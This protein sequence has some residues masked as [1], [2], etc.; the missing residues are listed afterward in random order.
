MYNHPYRAGRRK[1]F[2][3]LFPALVFLAGGAVMLLWNAILPD[4][5]QA[6]HITYWQSVGL[7]VLCRILFGGFHFG[8]RSRFPFGGPPHLRDK[9]ANMTEEERKQFKEQ[10]RKRWD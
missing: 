7:L 8:P 4:L 2:L 6:N 10:W 9:W 5:L 3:L 1:F